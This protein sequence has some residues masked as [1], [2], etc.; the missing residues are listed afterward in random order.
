MLFPSPRRGEIWDVD[1]SPSRGSEQGGIRP[2]LI[3]QNDRGN[4]SERFPNTIVLA[5]S[6]KGRD[7]PFHVRLAPGEDNGLDEVSWI[8]CEQ[9]LTITKDRLRGRARGRISPTQLE[10]VATA[11]KLSLDL[12]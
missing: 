12:P 8:K 1:W 9:V 5:I 7:I 2:A 4:A 6:T 11:L 10:E 3:V